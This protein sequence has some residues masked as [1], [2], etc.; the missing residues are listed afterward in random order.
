MRIK[1]AYSAPVKT[2]PLFANLDHLYPFYKLPS[3]IHLNII[4]PSPPWFP[5]GLSLT[6]LGRAGW[7]SGSTPDTYSG[8]ASLES[9]P[10]YWLFWLKFFVISPVPQSKCRDSTSIRLRQ[11]LSDWTFIEHPTIQRCIIKLI[12]T[13]KINPKAQE[14]YQNSECILYFPIMAVH[15]ASVLTSLEDLINHEITRCLDLIS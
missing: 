9:L 6:I 3:D 8:G 13:W 11:F 10:A 2:K 4:L 5:S 15:P 12:P 7:S 1:L 14:V